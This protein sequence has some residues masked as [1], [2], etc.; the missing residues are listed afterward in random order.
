MVKKTTIVE[1]ASK[2]SDALEGFLGKGESGNIHV[3]ESSAGNLRV[4]IGSDRF[5]GKGPAECQRIIWEYLDANVPPEQLVYCSGVHPMDA[6]EYAAEMFGKVSSAS[7]DLF[8]KG[9][10]HPNEASDE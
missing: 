1:A 8:I 5:K 2:I 4:I 10:D 3:F 9:T 6:A 7:V